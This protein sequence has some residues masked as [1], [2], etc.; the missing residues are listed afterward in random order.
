MTEGIAGVFYPYQTTMRDIRVV[1]RKR[2]P[3]QGFINCQLE[4]DNFLKLNT[5]QLSTGIK[6]GE[7]INSIITEYFKV[8]PVTTD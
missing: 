5:L 3:L 1:R 4:I 2:P 6:K 7:L 8:Y